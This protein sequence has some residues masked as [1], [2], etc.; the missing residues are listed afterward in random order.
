VCPTEQGARI[1]AIDWSGRSGADQ[2][3]TV[4]LA[5]AVNG[6][7]IRL[8]AGRSRQE[9]VELLIAE[10]DRNPDL[11]VGLDFA[12]SLP[13]W[14]LRDRALTPRAL[15][16]MVAD[17]ALTA[18]MRSLGLAQWLNS[19]EPPFW[20]TAQGHALLAAAQKFRRTEICARAAGSQPK[21]VFQLVGAGQVGR[22]SL[23]GMQAL[24]RLADA[25]FHIWPFDEAGL[26]LVVEVFPRLLTGLVI[27]SRQSERERYL[28]TLGIPNEFRRRAAASD[29]AFD[30]AVSAMVMS[31]SV[32]ELLALPN[33][34][35]D[36]IE[37]RIWQ[38]QHSLAYPKRQLEHTL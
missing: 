30:A 21:S 5:E 10:A 6:K 34:P 20:T 32:G 8:E 11:I 35:D 18:R 19:P 13:E 3:R 17:E 9:T 7:L 36:L 25:G 31:G 1:F 14:Y 22:G 29:D 28:S 27:K 24:H 23:Y 12:F 15:W 26:P 4:W 37:G 16:A 2:R 33:K 38:P